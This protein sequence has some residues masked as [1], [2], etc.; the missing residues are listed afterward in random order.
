[1]DIAELNVVNMRN[2]PPTPANYAQRSGRAGRSGQPALVR[3]PAFNQHT[4]PEFNGAVQRVAA[5]LTREPQLNQA[6][7]VTRITL[8]EVELLRMGA[9]KLI[10]GMP[11][12]VHIKT[13]ERTALSYLVKPLTDQFARA[14]RE[15]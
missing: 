11:A 15:R 6:Y 14:F 8:S 9:L 10:P 5:D 12:E 1:V 3:F 13:G 7:F 4:T 2:V